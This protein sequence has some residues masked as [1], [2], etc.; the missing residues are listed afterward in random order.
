MLVGTLALAWFVAL[1]LRARIDARRR[2]AGRASG[3]GSESLNRALFPLAGGMLLA[4]AQAVGDRFFATP[5]LQLALVPLF[6]TGNV[7]I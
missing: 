6:S 7:Y 2:A 4:V 3:T 1:W 5:I